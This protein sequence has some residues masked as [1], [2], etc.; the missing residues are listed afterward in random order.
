MENMEPYTWICEPGAQGKTAYKIRECLYL[1]IQYRD[2]FPKLAEAAGRFSIHEIRGTNKIEARWSTAPTEALILGGSNVA[3]QH[4]G[5][6]DRSVGRAV[7]TSGEQTFFTVVEAWN[8]SQPSNTPIY[9]AHASLSDTDL[10]RLYQWAQGRTPPLMIM[11]GE[12]GGFTLGPV[13]DDVVEFAYRPAAARQAEAEL[14][15]EPPKQV[16]IPPRP[17]WG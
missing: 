14:S 2:Q 7:S 17:T 3:P 5:T 15:D 1:A 10:L 11:L 16:P 12:E 6:G 9:F 8:K 13:D 4:G